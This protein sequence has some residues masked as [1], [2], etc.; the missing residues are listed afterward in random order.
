MPNVTSQP[1]GYTDALMMSRSAHLLIIDDEPQPRNMLVRL[2][3][4][5][6]YL[7]STAETGAQAMQRLMAQRFHVA[8]CDVKLPDD[9][10]VEL[11][12]AIK[13]QQPDAEVVV[14]TAFGTI[15]DAVR[16][17]QNGAFQ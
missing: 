2:F 6:G 4:S 13:S 16:A 8:L 11:T 5:E 10:G 7:V 15:S 3:T 14:V 9:N 1:K 12:L 17:V